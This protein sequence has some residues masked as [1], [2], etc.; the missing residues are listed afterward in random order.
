M[1]LLAAPPPHACSERHSFS[2]HRPGCDPRRRRGSLHWQCHWPHR[3]TRHHDASPGRFQV[4][5][6]HSLLA[7]APG[8]LVALASKLFPVAQHPD[9]SCQCPSLRPPQTW[10]QTLGL[11]RVQVVCE[12]DSEPG[13]GCSLG[14]THPAP[15][16]N[17][18]ARVSDSYPQSGR[19]HGVPLSTRSR[20]SLDGGCLVLLRASLRCHPLTLLLLL[21]PAAASTVK[22]RFGSKVLCLADLRPRKAA[23]QLHQ[24][25]PLALSSSRL[26]RPPNLLSIAVCVRAPTLVLLSAASSDPPLAASPDA[27]CFSPHQQGRGC[28]RR[29]NH[30]ALP[31]PE[32]ET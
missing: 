17:L 8:P 2:T 9:S 21:P 26:N 27:H 7:A 32:S 30:P 10:T 24:H 16:S 14:V 1:T 28:L 13:H 19:V 11:A 3:V 20:P 29:R 31:V 25:L 6:A 18:N 4:A 5:V 23:C 22:L 15:R 12:W